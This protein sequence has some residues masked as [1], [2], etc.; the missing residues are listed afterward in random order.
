MSERRSAIS[1]LQSEVLADLPDAVIEKD[2]AE[3]ITSC[4]GPTVAR[5]PCPISCFCAAATTG[6]SIGAVRPP[7]G[8]TM[9]APFSDG[10]MARC[11][12]TEPRHDRALNPS[13]ELP[14]VYPDVT[15]SPGA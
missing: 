15:T 9:A 10:Q 3:R 2:V 14:A 13:S 12:R 11:C 1:E 8:L 7:S 6:W 5:Q 4:T